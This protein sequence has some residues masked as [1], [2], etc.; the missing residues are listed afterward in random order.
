[1]SHRLVPDAAT[2]AVIRLFDATNVASNPAIS[3]TN[4]QAISTRHRVTS[5]AGFTSL[6][7][8]FALTTVIVVPIPPAYELKHQHGVQT[9][10]N[11]WHCS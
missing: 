10:H 7:S 5:P 9:G 3:A 1:M 2:A 6:S 8:L 11:G 4:S